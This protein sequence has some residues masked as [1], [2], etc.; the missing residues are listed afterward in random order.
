MNRYKEPKINNADFVNNPLAGSDFKI[1]ITKF[2]DKDRLKLSDGIYVPVEVE[3][4]RDEYCKVYT[5]S[6][7]RKIV[8]QLSPSAK[9]L[10]LWI[11]YELE[12]GKDYLWVNKRRYMEENSV[13]S[14]NTYKKAIAELARLTFICA[15]V[16]KDVYWINPKLMFAGSRINKYP[17]NIE[18]YKKQNQ[19]P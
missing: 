12:S 13:S 15:S 18:L 5:K 9:S 19:K 10:F 11:V 3:L 6:E 7:N 14:I 1:L 17:K 4:E 16:V 8:A 2:P